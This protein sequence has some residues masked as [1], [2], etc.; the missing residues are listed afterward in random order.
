MNQR[1]VKGAEIFPAIMMEIANAENEIIVASAWFTDEALFDA[2]LQKQ[3]VGVEVSIITA[4]IEHNDKLDFSK[5]QS[6]GAHVLKS[7]NVGYGMMH[8]KFCVIDQRIGIHGSYNWTVNAKRN[9]KESII[10]TDHRETVDDLIKY[11]NDMKSKIDDN[12]DLVPKKN[13]NKKIS[14]L[15]IFKNKNTTEPVVNNSTEVKVVEQNNNS[16]MIEIEGQFESIINSAIEGP[17]RDEIQILGEEN[18]R[19]VHGD[20][21]VLGKAMDSL[22]QLYVS[23]NKQVDDKKTILKSK[24]EAKQVSL[25]ADYKLIK[26]NKKNLEENLYQEQKKVNEQT[27]LD[28]KTEKK[29]NELSIDN[30]EKTII[31]KFQEKIESLKDSISNMKVEFVKPKIKYFEILPL[32]FVFFGLATALFLFYSSAAYIMLYAERDALAMVKLGI[33]P[34]AQVFNSEALKIAYQKD[35]TALFYIIAFVFIPLSI[36][37]A[38]HKAKAIWKS[39]GVISVILLDVFVA[40]R[41]THVVNQIAFLAKGTHN[42]EPFYH[43]ANFWIVFLLSAVPF[44]FFMKII[45]MIIVIFESRH[46][47]V[48]KEKMEFKVKEQRKKISEIES[49]IEKEKDNMKSLKE[50]VLRNDNRIESLEGIILNQNLDI[51]KSLEAIEEK[52]NAIERHIVQVAE[53]YKNRIDNDNIFISFSALKDRVNIFLKGWNK[54]LHDELSVSKA[55]KHSEYARIIADLWLVENVKRKDNNK[56]QAA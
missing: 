24:I 38:T 8:E 34:V 56:L 42:M 43:D 51:V 44:I 29:A 37:F 33:K 4:E 19:L 12:M 26:D 54:W 21:A 53:L 32:I 35:G 16:V 28:I 5:I 40:Y 10:I 11:F 48:A 25:V 55:T 14:L 45:D 31:P 41:I 3:K 52:Y 7:K 30:I 50:D 49:D 18:A 27:L 23:D 13:T 20:E 2:L 22:Y 39:L 1:L 36:A 9:N 17:N 47:E 15:G 6:V 46:P